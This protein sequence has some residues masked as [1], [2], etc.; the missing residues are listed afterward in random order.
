MCPAGQYLKR[1]GPLEWHV[2]ELGEVL[3]HF[4]FDWG[5]LLGDRGNHCC[6][7]NVRLQVGW[8]DAL[9]FGGH[10]VYG[11]GQALSA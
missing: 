6:S 11:F 5:L 3:S 9:C 8:Y 10:V 1:P 4:C 2:P 7:G